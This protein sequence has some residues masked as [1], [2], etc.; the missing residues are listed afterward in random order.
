MKLPRMSSLHDRQGKVRLWH[1]PFNG[2]LIDLRGYP[3]ATVEG[4]R[5]LDF[6]CRHVAYWKNA[7]IDIDDTVL[8]KR[9]HR[10][11]VPKL[12]L[13]PVLRPPETPWPALTTPWGVDIAF[14]EALRFATADRF[15]IGNR[16]ATEQ[17]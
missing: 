17:R 15:R 16:F 13:A 4:D 5:I 8:L 6:W 12:M 9:G 1:D 7:V 10:T 2:H 14:I 11:D 3:L